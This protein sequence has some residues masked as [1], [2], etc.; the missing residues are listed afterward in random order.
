MAQTAADVPVDVLQDWGVDT[1]FGF[2]GDGINGII[3]ALRKTQ[4]AIRCVQVRHE[5]SA[6]LMACG[7]A[8]LIGR[9]GVSLDVGEGV[10]LPPVREAIDPTAASPSS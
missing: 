3:E 4:D 1:L 9:L 10:P 5:E 2:P 6:A 7:Y 8:K